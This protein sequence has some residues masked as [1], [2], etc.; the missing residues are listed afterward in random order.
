[1]FSTDS[2]LELTLSFIPLLITLL[3]VFVV[4]W[5]AHNILI[6]KQ[7]DAG[8]EKLFSRQLIMLGL[9]LVALLATV[10]ALPVSE[11]SRNQIIGLIGLV[12]SGI[13]A[14]S[15]STIFANL[16]AG[17]MLRITKPFHTG[18]FV[19]V[20][21]F[22]GRVVERG[23]LDTEIQTE[24][25]DL[26]A[27]PNTFMITNPITVT[28]TSGTIIS[29]S[30]SLGYDIHNSTIET[31]LLQAATNCQLTDPFVHIVEL[32]DFSV[33]Y[34]IS[35]KLEEVKSL[36]SSRTRLNREVLNILHEN[37]IEIMSPS[38]MN[39]RKIPDD[40]KIIPPKQRVNNEN[41]ESTVDQVIFDKAEEAEQKE[42]LLEQLK[43]QLV[44]LNERLKQ[45]DENQKES[46]KLQIEDLTQKIK[47]FNKAEEIKE[48]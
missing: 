28:R 4:L 30:L 38:F 20:G 44:E 29:T 9:T 12:I 45:A 15:S 1:M 37:D 19:Q 46:F 41:S 27:L 11:S 39:Q 2:L 16:L 47:S 34:K 13:F 7:A 10:F 14:F 24:V 18:D 8:N 48:S 33:T 5:S 31:M 25:R 22:F 6:V 32:G 23:L 35:G 17:I 42:V 26:V 36:I 3:I 43:T 40:V 21:S